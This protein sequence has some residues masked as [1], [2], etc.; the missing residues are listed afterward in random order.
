MFKSNSAQTM[1]SARLILTEHQTML[2]DGKGKFEKSVNKKRR[3]FGISTLFWN[4]Y[5]RDRDKTGS[6]V[7][8][9]IPIIRSF[10]LRTGLMSRISNGTVG[11]GLFLYFTHYK[12]SL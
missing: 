7:M 8:D 9:Y 11:P 6:L 5:S 4:I 10:S 12:S 1:D 3:F 2:V